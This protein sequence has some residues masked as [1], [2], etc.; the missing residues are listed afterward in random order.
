MT[1]IVSSPVSSTID[2]PRHMAMTARQ[3][4]KMDEGAV[5]ARLL[6][7]ESKADYRRIE[8]AS[9]K[10]RTC[11]TSA[12]GKRLF[13]RFFSTLQL[14]AHFVSVIART[15][16]SADVVEQVEQAL[17]SRVDAVNEELNKAI[18]GAEALFH[19][20][21]ITSSATYDTQPLEIEIGII[22]SLGRRYL[23]VLV[24]LDQLMPLLQT[25]EIHEV[26]S[27]KELDIQRARLKRHLRD[28]ANAARSLATGLRRRMNA[29]DITPAPTIFVED[30][31]APQP[32]DSPLDAAQ[33]RETPGDAVHDHHP[34]A[35]VQGT[36]NGD[37]AEAPNDA[38]KKVL[39][40]HI[41]SE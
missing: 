21:G 9:I 41:G 12:E 1:T 19:A 38:D 5:N 15:K 6:A 4:F 3:I 10:M 25:L 27:T 34:I 40:A 14:N 7:R 8:A 22:S 16:L 32:A 17:R 35:D 2:D 20:N 24:K 28:V 13:I 30:P 31:D 26:I 36:D 39:D 11:F 23:E 18:D 37:D 29:A 33:P